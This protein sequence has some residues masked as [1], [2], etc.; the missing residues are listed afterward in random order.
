M[1]RESTIQLVTVTGEPGVGKTRLLAEFRGWVDARPELV[2]WRQ[3]RCLPYGDEIT[4]WALGEIVKAHAGI[5]ESDAPRRPRR[6]CTPRSRRPPPGTANG[7]RVRRAVHRLEAARL[8][9]IP[10]KRKAL[11]RTHR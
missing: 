10:S 9:S 4:F 11:H 1:L 2:Y 8:A 7:G 3:G 5:L 6:S